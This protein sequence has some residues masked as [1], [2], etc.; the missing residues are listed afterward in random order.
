MSG[1]VLFVLAVP[2]SKVLTEL[3][4]QVQYLV[5]GFLDT[6]WAHSE[7]AVLIFQKKKNQQSCCS[8]LHQ[9]LFK[10]ETLMGICE[11]KC[12][13]IMSVYCGVFFPEVHQ[14]LEF[15]SSDNARNNWHD[16]YTDQASVC[17]AWLRNCPQIYPEL[18]YN[19]PIMH[20]CHTASHSVG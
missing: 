11:K 1:A 6:W 9:F 12:Q 13:S 10:V 3:V 7:S 4:L 5:Q 17:P 14:Q 2:A 20:A 18:K 15:L 19:L 16:T 8:M